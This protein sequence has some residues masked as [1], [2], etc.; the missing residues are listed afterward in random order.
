[1]AFISNTAWIDKLIFASDMKMLCLINRTVRYLSIPILVFAISCQTEST[2]SDHV[3]IKIHTYDHENTT[4][5]AAM[6]EIKDGSELMI[7]K[8]RFE[9]LLINISEIHL[10]DKSEERNRIFG[11]YPDTSEIKR[12]Y[13]K[14]FTEDKKLT[15][16]FKETMAPIHHPNRKISKT[17]TVDELMEVASKFFYCDKVLPDSSVQAHICVGLNGV[18]EANWEKDYT[19]LEA[20]CYEAIFNRFD[21]ENSKIWDSFVSEKKEACEKYRSSISTL[22]QYLEDVKLSLFE[23]IKNDGILR[24]ELLDYYESNKGN[25]PFK[26]LI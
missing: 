8:R 14:K 15:A 25:L 18:K 1:M 24:K 12:L 4:K 9:Y 22:D 21:D 3:A 26:V 7:Y 23:R 5:A 10:P 13:L 11:L 20:F 16:Y 2:V 19:L 6:P 17:Y